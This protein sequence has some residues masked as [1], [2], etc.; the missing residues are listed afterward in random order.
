V[1]IQQE[2]L[3]ML[4]ERAK[5]EKLDNVQPILGSVV[6]PRL[7]EKSVDLILCVDVYHEFSNPEPMLASMR[8][9]L[10][11]G[12][13]VALVEF[14]PRGWRRADQDR[15]QDDQSPDH[16]RMARHGFKLVGQFDKLPWQHVMFFGRDD[17]ASLTA[18]DVTPWPAE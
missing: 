2:M 11:P 12:G 16:E 4:S 17:D 13:R 18:Q 8:R 6:D 15:T 10:R 3:H 7:P 5:A 14:S 9:S 1:D